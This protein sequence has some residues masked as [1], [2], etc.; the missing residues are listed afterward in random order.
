MF[1][2]LNNPDIREHIV[3]ITDDEEVLLLDGFDEAII[4]I[5]NRINTP[6]LA[7]YSWESIINILIERDGLSLDDAMEYTDFNILGA[8]VGER[9]PIIVMPLDM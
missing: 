1:N 5:T 4:G 6:V 3:S 8:W 9:T 2:T 7:V